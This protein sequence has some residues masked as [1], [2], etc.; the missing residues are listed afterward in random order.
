MRTINASLTIVLLFFFHVVFAQL[1]GGTFQW[2]NDGKAYYEM[3]DGNIVLFD[4]ISGVE[5]VIIDKTTLGKIKGE[6]DSYT[7]SKDEKKVLIFANTVQVWRYNTKGDYWLLNLQTNDL[8]QLGKGKSPQSLMFAKFSPDGNKVG[9]VSEH[10]IYVD[11]LVTTST[12]QLTF[13]GTRKLING[14]F[15]W[16]YEEE[17]NCRD[18]FRWSPD[19][20][21]IAFWQIDASKIRDYYML[22]T[23]DSLYSVVVPVEYPKTGESP[24]PAKIGVVTLADKKI[25]WMNID[26]DPSQHYLTRMEWAGKN[27]IVVQQLNRSQQESKL[28]YCNVLTGSSDLFFYE[29]A[30][31]WIEN[32][33]YWN[34]D[35]PTGWNWL[36]NGKEFIWVSEKDGWRHLYKIS[37]DGK[38]E[39]LL[40]KG[41]YDI[42]TIKCIDE[43]NNFI[44]FTAS[45]NNPTQRY[46]YRIK[47]AGKGKAQL[48]TPVDFNGTNNYSISPSANLAKHTFSNYNTY[49]VTHWVTLPAHKHVGEQAF[50]LRINKSLRVEFT[51]ITTAEGIT[52]DAWISYPKNFDSTKKYPVLFYVYGEPG[53]S[54]VDDKYGQ[55]YPYLYDGDLT[56]DGYFYVSID[57]RG[58]PVLKGSAWRKAIYKNIGQI[59]I[60]D[61]ALG[62]KVL[63]QRD[64]FDKERVAVWGW[65]GGGATTLHLLF[66]YPEIFKTGISIAPL[67]NLFSYDNIYQERYMGIPQEDKQAY[68]NGS[69]ITYAKNLKGNLLVVHGTGDDNVHYSNTEVLINELVK[70]GKQFQLMAYPNRTHSMREGEGTWLHLK[71]LFTKFLREKCPPKEK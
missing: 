54:T 25:N 38:K 7:F 37:S 5:K 62:A 63:L 29:K 46:L 69:A 40:T 27:K 16:V 3:K 30:T 48:L 44:Y 13:D 43:K 23:T 26:G 56:G 68:I 19:G 50:E 52:L 51:K 39:T 8:K 59:N 34:D 33:D 36:N 20:E 41:E 4:L 35:D 67:T 65:S 31:G 70:N 1:P 58:T 21:S 24:S 22:N 55:Q 60:R 28:F 71:A 57:N 47:M 45:P 10:N 11:D 61:I 6:V 9:Y 32:K 53:R 15:D 2:T 42:A 12:T 49:P 17:L 14:T 18:G 64:Y 66:Q